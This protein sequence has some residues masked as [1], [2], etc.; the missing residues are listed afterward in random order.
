MKFFAFDCFDHIICTIYLLRHLYK[1]RL[2]SE[3]ALWTGKNLSYYMLISVLFFYSEFLNLWKMTAFEEMGV[4]PELGKA[5]EEL[6]WMLPTDVQ[7]EAV[8]MILGGGDVLMAAET[9]SGKNGC[10]LS[11]N[12]TNRAW[13]PQGPVW[14]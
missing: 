5:V 14:R 1:L 6:D 7:A 2:R 4:M 10:L 11:S 13:S 8:P 9:G 3:A 12:F